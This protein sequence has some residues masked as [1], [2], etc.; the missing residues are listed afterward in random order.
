MRIPEVALILRLKDML[1]GPLQRATKDM[2]SQTERSVAE[3]RRAYSRLAQA[4]EQLGIRSEHAIQ[5]EIQQTEAAYN[6]MARA[7]SMSANEQSRAYQAMTN[8]VRELRRELGMVE[9]QQ[10][11]LSGMMR[12]GLAVGAGAWAAGQVLKSPIERTMSYDKR[13]A[14]MANT[15]YAEQDVAGRR[16]GIE[17]LRKAINDAIRTG[18]GTHDQAAE[19]LD[20]M[21]ASGTVS[22]KDAIKMLPGIMK[23]ATASGTDANALATIAIRA[24]QSFKIGADDLPDILSAA[25]QA[26]QAGGF[27]LKDMAKWLPQQMAMA[28]NLGLKGK[29][30]FAKLAAW[31]QASVI[32]AGTK[33]EAGNNLRDLLNELNTPHFRGYM[34]TEYLNNG[35]KMKKGQKEKRLKNIDQVFLDYQS[36]GV[37]KVEA[38]LDMMNTIFSRNK[39]YKELQG[40]LQALPAEDKDGRRQIIEAMAAQVQGTQVGKVFHNQQ[41]LMAFLGLM[42][43]KEYTKDVLGKVNAEYNLPEN[44]SAIGQGFQLISSTNAFQ[45]ERRKNENT[46]SEQKL[47]AP[48]NDAIGA[49]SGKLADYA[50]KYPALGVSIVG[51]TT[52]LTALSAAAAG[53]ALMRLLTAGGAA[54]AAAP[55]GAAAATTAAQLSPVIT[56]AAGPALMLTS[57]ATFTT[58]EEDDEVLNGKERWKR[59]HEQYSPEVIEAARKKYQ[60]WYKIGDGYAA[61]NERWIQQYL[62]DQAAQKEVKVTVELKNPELL[63][64]QVNQANATEARRH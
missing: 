25:M 12:G 13:L 43:N 47:F 17:T 21:I 54:T 3:Q 1:S 8:R 45:E 44:K 24:K 37:D 4:R 59:I 18:G 64:V 56:R 46:I 22:D 33:D 32:T 30:G 14:Y 29:D 6:R 51:A 62:Q 11:N 55:A 49:A 52:A 9:R 26:G 50:Q 48:L 34:A 63:A 20:T 58:S 7:G 41:S 27:E 60:P 31:N 28:S 53:S 15:A 35:R 57:L 36:R 2:A 39:K 61:A 5:R 40:K 19:A 42:N 38:T 16:A 10:R 23:A